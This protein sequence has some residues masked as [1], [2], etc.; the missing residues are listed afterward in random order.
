[1]KRTKRLAL[2]LLAILLATLACGGPASPTALPTET[3]AAS[4]VTQPGLRLDGPIMIGTEYIVIENAARVAALADMLATL[5]LPA[6]KPLPENFSWGEM[7]P[8]PEAPLDFRRL[9]D[10]VAKFQAAGFTELVLALKPHSSWASNDYPAQGLLPLRGGVKTEYLDDYEN[11]VYSIVERYDAD[12]SA[13]MPGLL[14]PIRFYEI[15]T[16]FSSYEPEPVEEY[17]VILE[18]AYSAAHRAYDDAIVAHAAFLTTLAFAAH[19]APGEY[20]AAFEAI[21]DHNHGLADMRQVLDRPDLFDVVNIHSLGDPYEIEAIVAWLNYEMGQRGY[22]KRIIISDTATTPFIA[23]GPATACDRPPNLMGQII[24][25]ATEADRCRLADYF[26]KLV[27]GDQDAVRWT[28]GLAAQNAVKKV[29]I[30]A[31]QGILLINTAFTEDLFWLKLPL[32]QAGAGT[33][34]WAGLVDVERREYR[35]AYYAL[36]LVVEKIG[37][38]TTVEKPSL[39]EGIWAYRFETPSGPLWALWY[40]DRALYLPGETPPSVTVSLPFEAAS[41]L[42]TFTPTA[43]GQTEPETQTIQAVGG[44][45]TFD[46]GA[47]PV[48]VE[49]RP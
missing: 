20:E 44:T 1:M 37:Q 49:G 43:I 32:A 7:Q 30:S 34:A 40:D 22:R 42:L 39:G 23:W 3:R 8:S 45:L 19:P 48:F 36:A 41:A 14:H 33:S 13:D 35:P 18:R 11:W 21:P 9:D 10:F 46:L 27:N 15:G 28:Q 17:L 12:G 25:P 6:A 24:P 2:P 31:G 4:P 47:T 16:E 38:Y 5:A 26:T 29:V